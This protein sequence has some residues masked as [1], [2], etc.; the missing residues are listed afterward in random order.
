MG[1]AWMG[2]WTRNEGIAMDWHIDRM[3]KNEPN[4]SLVWSQ[5]YSVGVTELDQTI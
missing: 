1:A 5:E 4:K 3:A 2:I